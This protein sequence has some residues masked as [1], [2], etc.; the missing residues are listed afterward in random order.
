MGGSEIVSPPQEFSRTSWAVQPRTFTS[1][2]ILVLILISFAPLTPWLGFYWDDWP[3]LWFLKFRGPAGFIEIFSIDRPLLGYLFTGTTALIG[4]H[5]LAWQVFGLISRWFAALSFWWALRG[6]WPARKSLALWAALLFAVYP[7][8]KQ[9]PLS[10]TYSHSWLILAVFLLSLGIQLR[11]VRRETGLP[12][13]RWAWLAGAWALSSLVMFTSEYFFGLEA[14][15]PVLLLIVLAGEKRSR[16]A[17]VRQAPEGAGSLLLRA[18]R[19]WIPY[20]ASMAAFL[21]WRL[22]L[23]DTP[24]GDVVILDQVQGDPAGS[25]SALAYTIVSDIYEAGL[26]AWGEAFGLRR[27]SGLEPSFLV[28]FGLVALA[29]ALTTWFLVT[30][31]YVPERETE[32]EAGPPPVFGPGPERR[33]GSGFSEGLQA[34]ALGLLALFVA[35]WPFWTTGLP[36]GLTFPF[37]RFLLAMMPGA[38]LLG[39]GVARLL[40]VFKLWGRPD[41]PL[42]QAAGLALLAGAAAGS[43]FYNA[44]QYRQEWFD[45]QAFFWQLSWRAPEIE[46]GTTLL[47]SELPHRRSSDY[48][49]SAPLNWT[50]RPDGIPDQL[51]YF[52]IDI[53]SRLD[54]GPEEMREE[55]AI[56]L[57]YRTSSFSGSTGQAVVLFYAPPRCLRVVE[58]ER[59]LLVPRKPKFIDVAM[60]LSR[61][62]LISNAETAVAPPPVLGPEPEHGWCYYFEKADLARQTDQW[63]E[64]QALAEEVERLGLAPGDREADEWSPFITGYAQNGDWQSAVELTR[65]AYQANT[66]LSDYYCLQWRYLFQD[67]PPS[68]ER[69]QASRKIEAELGCRFP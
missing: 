47:T 24:R 60:P 9:Q 48:T 53:G 13:P 6:L 18:A 8:F 44:V 35:G 65:R 22:R 43:N 38:A 26:A 42:L 37:D 54:T 32:S 56:E 61:V 62:D 51:P 7:G 49:L 66:K 69:A 33:P 19:S 11:A 4:E 25:I 36:I 5:P 50:Y 1:A 52:L 20:L 15:R 28:G 23:H 2:L 29:S 55:Q 16:A 17:G 39:A 40:P 64:L 58:P 45:Q 14:L 41:R 27:L 31:S 3:T 59:D 63:P 46:P 21:Y 34:A 67:T 12:G 10:L 30:R 57:P 68:N